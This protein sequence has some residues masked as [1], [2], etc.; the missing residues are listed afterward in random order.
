MEKMK[1]KEKRNLSLLNDY[2]ANNNRL[3]TTIER[4]ND[5]YI[6]LWESNA[7]KEE[8]I[9]FLQSK[10][11]QELPCIDNFKDEVVLCDCCHKV[12]DIVPTSAFWQPN[13]VLNVEGEY[14][15]NECLSTDDIEAIIEAKK[16]DFEKCIYAAQIDLCALLQEHDFEFFNG[17]TY[18]EE[19]E[20]DMEKAVELY[21]D[22]VFYCASS[23]PFEADVY[24]LVRNKKM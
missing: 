17:E 21:Q 11:V 4:T 8:I 18:S 1:A 5:G 9:N 20:R 22:C 7:E 3:Y 12:L 10:N 6:I 2:L 16:N 24:L 23:T 14:I 19:Y 15:C 13:W